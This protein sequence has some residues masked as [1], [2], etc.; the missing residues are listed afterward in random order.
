MVEPINDAKGI[1][2]SIV[3]QNFKQDSNS[4]LSFNDKEGT[5][6]QFTN[7]ERNTQNI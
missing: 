7:L 2:L 5:T 4:I 3:Q 6:S 1:N